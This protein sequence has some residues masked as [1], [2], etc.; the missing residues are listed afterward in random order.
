MMC[1]LVCDVSLSPLTTFIQKQVVASYAWTPWVWNLKF[2]PFIPLSS[3]TGTAACFH[4][5]L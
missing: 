3:A 4:E 2:N 1:W 5:R